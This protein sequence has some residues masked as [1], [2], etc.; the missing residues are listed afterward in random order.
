[1]D[2][3][4]DDDMQDLKADLRLLAWMLAASVVLN[5]ILLVSCSGCGPCFSD[6]VD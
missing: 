6:I 2:P 5:L 3:S 1:M 4:R